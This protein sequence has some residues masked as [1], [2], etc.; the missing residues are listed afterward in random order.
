VAVCPL[1]GS[2]TGGAPRCPSCGLYL[3]VADPSGRAFGGA[4]V[5][6]LLLALAAAY[7]LTLLAVLAAR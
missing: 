4:T 5:R 7:V 2:P 6:M 1:C 3:E